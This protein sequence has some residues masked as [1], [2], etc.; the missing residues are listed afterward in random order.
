MFI[1]G[2]VSVGDRVVMNHKVAVEPDAVIGNDV[3]LQPGSTVV[4]GISLLEGKTYAN[5]PIELYGDTDVAELRVRNATRRAVNHSLTTTFLQILGMW[6][7][8]SL[9]IG[10]L[11]L[12]LWPA[13]EIFRVSETVGLCFLLSVTPIIMLAFFVHTIPIIKWIV[14]GR[15][16]E[17]R[18]YITPERLAAH[19]MMG[20]LISTC[21]WVIPSIGTPATNNLM[22]WTMGLTYGKQCQGTFANFSAA[23]DL[24][25]MGDRV[26]LGANNVVVPWYFE[27]HEMVFKEV[28]F[29]D[30]AV[31]SPNCVTL[32]GS[33]VHPGGVLGPS[34]VLGPD[35]EVQRGV[36]YMNRA[37]ML[38]TGDVLVDPEKSSSFGY[39][40]FQFSCF[41]LTVG[42]YMILGVCALP[43]EL[44]FEKVLLEHFRVDSWSLTKNPGHWILIP[45]EHWGI[46]FIPLMVTMVLLIYTVVCSLIVRAVRRRENGNSKEFF[47]FRFCMF[48]WEGHMVSFSLLSQ[49]HSTSLLLKGTELGPMLCR[50]YGGKVGR[51]VYWDSFQPTEFDLLETGN[52]CVLDLCDV[53]IHGVVGVQKTHVFTQEPIILGNNCV[54]RPGSYPL[55]PVRMGMNCLLGT[56]AIVMKGDVVPD[57]GYACGNPARVVQDASSL[58]GKTKSPAMSV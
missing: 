13:N 15:V 43:V 21:S 44:F 55:P 54:L 17:G 20:R 28:H 57:N 47:D 41:F 32:A 26:W 23:M 29:K 48:L 19:W 14:L 10:G 40:F 52:D 16:Q 37:P 49:I 7:Y 31:L 50:I 22:Y 33:T 36:V 42:T 3:E 9:W 8:M 27:G 34:S 58:Y 51:N 18:F 11:A 2:P 56:N 5:A 25:K 39:M 30:G 45:L 12:G 24:V 53:V 38:R 46:V 6:F 35:G 1:L 4:R